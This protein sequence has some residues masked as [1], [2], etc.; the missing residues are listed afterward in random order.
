MRRCFVAV[1]V[2][3][4]IVVWLNIGVS[5]WYVSRASLLRGVAPCYV[6]LCSIVT[7]YGSCIVS[8]RYACC[9]VVSCLGALG[10][11]L[12]CG[13]AHC[14]AVLC[15]VT[16]QFVVL[17]SMLCCVMAYRCLLVCVGV[18]YLVGGPVVFSCV[19]VLRGV[20]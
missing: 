20:V 10:C 19:W 3:L 2:A 4:V 8:W 6:L 5:C 7:S 17:C 1:L 13:V 15:V 12:V 11:T 18:V 9:V 14:H 16:W